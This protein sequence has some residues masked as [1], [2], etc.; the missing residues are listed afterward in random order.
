MGRQ[1]APPWGHIQR[2]LDKSGVL[3]ICST[4]PKEP[5]EQR[6]EEEEEAEEGEKGGENGM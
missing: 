4:G 5:E 6:K 1:E 3:Y 2:G